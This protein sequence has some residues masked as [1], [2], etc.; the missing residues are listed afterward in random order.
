MIA[1]L[2]FEGLQNENQNCGL[3]ETYLGYNSLRP[4]IWSKT[5]G[6]NKKASEG[7]A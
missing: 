4:F 2:T 5:W 7:V 6:L 3:Q 1:T